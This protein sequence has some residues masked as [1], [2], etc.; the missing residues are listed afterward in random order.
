[1]PLDGEYEP[2]PVAWVRDQVAEYES[3]GGARGH[4]ATGHAGDRLD[5]AGAKS[6][7]SAS[8]R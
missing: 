3:S 5:H 8:P 2:S 7:R 6:G 1:M 4:D